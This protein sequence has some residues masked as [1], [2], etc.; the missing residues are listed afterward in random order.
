M[1]ATNIKV[2]IKRPTVD[3]TL[4][5]PESGQLTFTPIRRHVDGEH[6]VVIPVGFPIELDGDGE[7]TVQL[8]PTDGTW[9]WQVEEIYGK[10]KYV[11]Y[12]E[13][14]ASEQEIDYADLT[15]V[16]PQDL[17][18]L[19]LSGSVLRMLVASSQEEMESLTAE[20]PGYAIL[21]PE[22][23]SVVNAGETMERLIQLREQA[24]GDA[25]AVRAVYS[26]VM[27]DGNSVSANAA[28][29][30][31]AAQKTSDAQ[32]R[33]MSADASVSQRVNE[34]SASADQ[35]LTR[36]EAAV[37]EVESAANG[38]PGVNIGDDDGTAGTQGDTAGQEA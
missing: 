15:E 34:V 21:F 10:L 35:A 33:V 9:A 3:G 5:G 6:N 37:T 14:P 26:N 25:K 38:V 11:R 12:V 7:A 8:E 32:A 2:S 31:D 13:V 29:V 30:A 16:R 4:S 22:G 17:A 18:P 28:T 20:Y 19:A 36:I 23:E 24:E 1:T 27:S